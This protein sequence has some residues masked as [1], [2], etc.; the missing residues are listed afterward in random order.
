MLAA[1]LVTHV[2]RSPVDLDLAARQ[3]DAY[4]AALESNGW[5]TH[6]VEPAD[7]CPD[8]PFV[9]DTMVVFGDLAVIAR[10]G[11]PERQPETRG[12]TRAV[13]HLGYQV[14]TITFPG[15]LDGGDV[16]KLGRT[17]F[18]GVGGRTNSAGAA[19]LATLTEDRGITVV[20]VPISG[21]LHLK[22]AVTALPDGTLLANVGAIGRSA[23]LPPLTQAPDRGPWRMVL[24]G[25]DRALLSTSAPRTAD[26]LLERGV[27]P[28][29]V[30]ISEFEKLESSVTCLSV[31]LRDRPPDPARR[32]VAGPDDP[33]S[34]APS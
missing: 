32:R 19:Q 21:V 11:A 18:V 31:R 29:I 9:E 7:D 26:L 20:T 16:L 25:P 10:P 33:Q 1:G 4:V 12:A 34:G 15:T 8:A 14:R 17:W 5:P 6:E 30:D 22:T 13:D 3:W 2:D 27:T 24:L 23:V 28:V